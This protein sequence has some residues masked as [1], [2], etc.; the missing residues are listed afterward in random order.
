V[1]VY[2]YIYILYRY[3]YKKYEEYIKRI[4]VCTAK[5]TEEEED[6]V[7]PA[8]QKWHEKKLKNSYKI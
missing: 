7:Y 2:I 4:V 1:S 6:V 3:I 5:M 8:T